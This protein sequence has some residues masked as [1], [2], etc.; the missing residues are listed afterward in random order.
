M[1]GE[2]SL[3]SPLA[4]CGVGLLRS[5]LFWVVPTVLPSSEDWGGKRG[6]V[7]VIVTAK[8]SEEGGK[9]CYLA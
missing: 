3:Q 1:R 9:S 7:R 5:C 8:N 6:E 4:V 2:D